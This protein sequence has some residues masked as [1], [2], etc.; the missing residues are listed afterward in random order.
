MVFNVSASGYQKNTRIGTVPLDHLGDGIFYPV[1]MENNGILKGMEAKEN[2]YTVL[3]EDETESII[4][5]FRTA[6]AGT[7][8]QFEK[9]F[10]CKVP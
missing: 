4:Y 6:M 8:D 3:I 9:D 10:E 1:N 7:L 2:Y 5:T